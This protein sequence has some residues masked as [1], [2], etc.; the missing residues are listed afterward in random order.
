MITLLLTLR[1]DTVHLDVTLGD[2]RD[3]CHLWSGNGEDGVSTNPTELSTVQ[4]VEF[5]RLSASFPPKLH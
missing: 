4:K 1:T 2:E 5:S 3:G